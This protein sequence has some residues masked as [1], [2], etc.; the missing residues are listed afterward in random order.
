[1]DLQAVFF[2]LDGTLLDTADDLGAATNQ[3]L[4]EEGLRP[5]RP[6]EYRCAVSD[7]ALALI[8][9]G[10]QIDDDHPNLAELRQRLLKHYAKNLSEHS[11]PFEGIVD[12]IAS[13]AKNNIAWGIATNKPAAYAEPL[14][15]E[16]NFASK[17]CSII[18]P[19]HVKNR[20]P[21]PESLFIACEDAKCNTEN[22]VYIGDHRRDIEC[23]QNAN[24]KTIC[25]AYGYIPEHENYEDWQADLT[26]LHAS[27]IWPI[28]CHLSDKTLN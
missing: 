10:F 5:L 2:D 14:M 23:G 18:C 22:A 8:K 19:D 3:V 11:R 4:I 7:G 20:K 12:L 9:L 27:E 16:F 6:D 24:M 13:L 15:Q 25:A 17:P 1:M 26:V 21:D 28:L